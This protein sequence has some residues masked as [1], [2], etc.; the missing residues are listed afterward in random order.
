MKLIRRKK[1][2][3]T[4]ERATGYVKLGAK[5]LAAQRVARRALKRYRFTKRAVPLVGLA[6]IGAAIA[7]KVRGGGESASATPSYTPPPPATTTTE[8]S[9]QDGGTAASAYDS[10]ESGEAPTDETLGVEA[11]NESTPPPPEKT[12]K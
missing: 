11:P 3:T 4:F 7:K 2:P 12:T 8:T 1:S 9:G 10:A 5:G 6:A